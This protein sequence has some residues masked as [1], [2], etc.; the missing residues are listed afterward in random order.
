MECIGGGH[1]LQLSGG[2]AVE[3]AAGARQQ[4]TAY[5]PPVAA[6]LQALKY[7][8]VF[9]V[10]RD[11]LRTVFGSGSHD[12]LTGADQRLLIG[13]GD[14]FPLPD[15]GQRR[16]KTHA[17]HDGGDKGIRLLRSGGGQKSLLPCQHLNV[18]VGQALTQHTGGIRVI[19]RRKARPELPRLLLQK[20]DIRMGGQCRHGKAQL[21]GHLQCLPS[22]RAGR[23]QKG[24]GFRHS[25]YSLNTMSRRTPASR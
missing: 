22:D 15:G 20:V 24:D 3:R 2:L 12:Q 7:S 13:Q 4:D 17:A 16:R 5:L 19:H 1:T 18:H 21:P 10:H 23:S 9:T 11:D 25:M 14:A 8:G 6:A